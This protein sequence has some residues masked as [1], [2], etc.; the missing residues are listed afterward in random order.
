MVAAALG[1]VGLM[2]GC[3]GSGVVQLPDCIDCRPVTMAMDQVLE[4]PL[5]S[6]RTTPNPEDYE[7]VIADLGTM[8]VVSAEQGARPEDP[9]EFPTGMSTYILW[10]LAPTQPGDTETVFQ[11]VRTDDPAAQPGLTIVIEIIVEE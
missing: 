9:A 4:V 3:G 2:A 10:T 8:E 7:W 6:D 1:L 11:Y 5:G